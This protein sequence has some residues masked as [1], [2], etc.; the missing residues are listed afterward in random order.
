MFVYTIPELVKKPKYTVG[1]WLDI[2]CISVV[3]MFQL[4]TS[5][6]WFALANRLY[7]IFFSDKLDPKLQP[8]CNT[9]KSLL[10]TDLRFSEK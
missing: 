6:T 10:E 5:E 2:Y 3:Y 1:F 7:S 8:H 9:L 4:P